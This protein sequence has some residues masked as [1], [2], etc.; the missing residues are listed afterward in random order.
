[1]TQVFEA[2]QRHNAEARYSIWSAL[3]GREGGADPH[4]AD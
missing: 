3:R 1:M 2:L 4:D